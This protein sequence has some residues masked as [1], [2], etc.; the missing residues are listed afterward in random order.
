MTLTIGTDA[1]ITEAAADTYWTDRGN[2]DWTALSS[3]DKEV[4]IRKATDWINNSYTFVGEKAT[5]A[6]RLQWPREFAY[7]DGF[8]IANTAIPDPV[9]EAT[10]IVADLFRQGTLNLDGI[11]SDD[12]AAVSMQK[13]DVITVQYDTGKRIRGKSQLNHVNDL[14]R[15]VT[16]ARGQLT[17]AI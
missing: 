16:M 6:Q 5:A 4:N 14:L 11:I 13:V 2:T 12:E 15:S 3:G 9:A 8:L 7:A 1:Y 17:R 10:A